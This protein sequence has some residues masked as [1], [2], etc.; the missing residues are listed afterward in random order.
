[1]IQPLTSWLLYMIWQGRFDTLRRIG[2]AEADGGRQGLRGRNPYHRLARLWIGDKIVRAIFHAFARMAGVKGFR[3]PDMGRLARLAQAHYSPELRGGEG[4]LEVA[5][6]LDTA[7]RHDCDLVISVK[8]FGCLPSSGV[9][10]GIQARVRSL[11]PATGFLSIETTGDAEENAYSR[12]QMA[13]FKAKSQLAATDQ[14][15][16]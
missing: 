11:N 10:D 14:R 9:S 15:N 8:P 1:M 5:K 12:V 2:L 6:L 16:T 13:I 4:H 7:E 3:L